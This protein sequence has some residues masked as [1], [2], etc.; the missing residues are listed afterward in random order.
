VAYRECDINVALPY[1]N[2]SFDYVVCLEIIEHVDDPFALS[3]ECRREL[4]KNGS[5]YISTPN[6][7]NMRSRMKFLLDGSFLF[8][9][10]PPMEWEERDGRPSVHVHPICYHELEYYLF[11][12]GLN[13]VEA[14]TNERSTSWK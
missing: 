9:N 1:E 7:L 3:R 8:F 2:E 13:V 11:R 10:L 6:I 14:F 12:A 4:R 5:L